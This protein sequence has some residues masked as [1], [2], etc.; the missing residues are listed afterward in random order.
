MTAAQLIVLRH[1]RTDWNATGRFQGQA[2]IG[3]DDAGRA[4]AE[5][6]APMLAE[7]DAD[8]ASTPA[9]CPGPTRPPPRWPS[10]PVCRSPT[11]KRLREIHVGSW[12]GLTRRRGARAE[13]RAGRARS[14]AVRTSAARR[15]ARAVGGGRAGGRGAGRDRR[16]AADGSTVVVVMHGLAGRVGVCRLVGFPSEHWQRL[17]GLHN[18]GWIS[19]DRHR[20]GDYWRIEAYN[21]V[22]T[23]RRAGDPGT[24]LISW[25]HRARASISGSLHTGAL[26]QL[27]ARFHGM[28]EVRGSNPLSSTH[29]RLRR[30][31]SGP[32]AAGPPG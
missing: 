30:D 25:S 28:E 13:S 7:L 21:A 3:L 2:D 32:F 26:A 24:A 14:G 18:C 10:S 27:V 31:Y 20:S 19:L 6:A 1:G 15:P 5:Q 4:Q 11:D 23:A 9:T 17:G 29:S 16:A 8:G 12:E 22:A